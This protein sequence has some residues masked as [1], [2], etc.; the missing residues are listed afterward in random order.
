MEWHF[1]GR[2]SRDV[3]VLREEVVGYLRRHGEAEADYDGAALVVSE[4]LSN[5]WR[6]TSSAGWLE[7]LWR[8]DCATL[9]LRDVGP[10]FDWTPTPLAADAV[11]GRGLIIVDT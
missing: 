4:L 1:A 8:D 5:V 2:D 6:H 7:A 9:I 10:G 11:G 3:A